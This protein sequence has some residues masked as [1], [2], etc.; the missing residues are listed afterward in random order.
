MKNRKSIL[1]VMGEPNSIFT[2]ILSK[3]INKLILKKEINK[4][5]I[6]IGSKK[7][8]LAQLKILKSKLKFE[9]LENNFTDYY[10]LKKKVYLIDVEFKFKK[11]FDKIS[12][13]S[14]KYISNCFKKAFGLINLNISNF[15]INGPISK[16]HFLEKKYPGVTEY[17]FQKSKEKKSINPIMLIYNKNLS[18]S[19][20]TTHV[21]LKNVSK[22]IK[23]NLIVNN[24]LH[25]N[26]FYKNK[27]KKKPK[28]AILGLNPHCESK[29]KINEEKK[30]I[31]PAINKLRKKGI[32]INGPFSA[33]TFFLKNNII[34]YDSV[35]GMYH[36]QILTPFKTLFGFDASNL[37]LGLNFIRMSVDHGPNETMM[38]KNK[39]NPQSLEN[40]FNLIKLLK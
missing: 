5:I 31:M 14:K 25:I 29:T 18:V 33:D 34:K 35:I 30:E 38:G 37:T 6:L 10:K 39:S 19:P 1:I 4:P 22:M 13:N 40:I 21:P 28:I 2:E 23:E 3:T 12:T 20:I 7:L 15:L 27:L 36:D 11:P 16:K 8:I 9:M 17:V 32:N 24:T 26:Q